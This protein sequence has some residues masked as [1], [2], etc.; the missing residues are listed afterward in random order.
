MKD[1]DN[2]SKLLMSLNDVF[3]DT[4]DFA[5]RKI[6]F[7]VDRGRM[8]ERSVET[9]VKTSGRKRRYKKVSNDVKREVVVSKGDEMVRL[10]VAIENQS[11]VSRIMPER[12]LMTTSLYLDRWVNETKAQHKKRGD[13]QKGAEWMD[14]VKKGDNPIPIMPL[15]VNFGKEPWKEARRLSEMLPCPSVLKEYMADCP[16]N[17]ISPCELTAEELDEFPVGTM[18]AVSKCIRYADLPEILLHEMKT[19]P[20]FELLPSEAYDVI[21]IATRLKLKKNKEKEG[22]DMRR[23]ISAI[24]AYLLKKG[25]ES[26]F[27]KGEESGF[28]KGEESGFQK[29]EESGFQKAVLVFIQNRLTGRISQKRIL[30]DLQNN[31][32]VDA[33]KAEQF[34]KE[35]LTK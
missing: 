26:G 25:E 5:L 34:L 1:M 15:V 11:Y 31:F 17:V 35:A 22:N 29:G 18:R 9:V 14:G 7:K 12:C 30:E 19:D 28:Q 4:V 23:E 8:E 24:E 32:G 2:A 3:A 13:L 16:T 27:Q 21:K 20:S 10:V 6:G 33:I